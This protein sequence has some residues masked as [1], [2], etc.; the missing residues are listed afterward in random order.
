MKYLNRIEL[1]SIEQLN[2]IANK[3][4]VF[5]LDFWAEWCQ[6][7][8]MEDTLLKFAE[9]VLNT[10]GRKNISFNVVGVN[11]DN[12]IFKPYLIENKIES[13]PYIRLYFRGKPVVE[14]IGFSWKSLIY[15]IS[16]YVYLEEV[17]KIAVEKGYEINMI[18]LK[19]GLKY[20][21]LRCP[22]RPLIE[23]C[24]CDDIEEYIKKL[25]RCYCGLFRKPKASKQDESVF[26]SIK[27]Q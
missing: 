5:Y 1:E 13:I 9:Y 4:Q 24:P 26:F 17:D 11:C 2:E 6:P 27:E 3:F 16:D 14:Y 8:K 23:K 22:C 21:G 18:M 20:H 15:M 25:G 19:A 10:A 12:D 7:C